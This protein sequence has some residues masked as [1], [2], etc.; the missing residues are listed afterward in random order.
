[1]AGSLPDQAVV[2]VQ[3]PDAQ[4]PANNGRPSYSPTFIFLY[5][6]IFALYFYISYNQVYSPTGFSSDLPSH[7]LFANQF[8]HGQY[9]ASYP[10]LYIIWFVVSHLLQ[11]TTAQG[12][13]IVDSLLA[14][15]IAII[16]RKVL[17]Y[18]QCS[19]IE[20][21]VYTAMLMI[22]TPIYVPFFN[23]SLYL[24]QIN[25]TVYHNPTILAV[26]PFA[27]LS[28]LCYAKWF[29]TKSANRYFALAVLAILISIVMKPNFFLVFA[30]AAAIYLLLHG[31]RFEQWWKTG[32]IFVL[33]VVVLAVQYVITYDQPD[34]TSHIGL[35]HPFR[36][37]AI[38]S[39]NPLISILISVS[40][41]L[42]ILVFRW[43][44]AVHN[45]YLM[46]SWLAL[47][48]GIVEYAMLAEKGQRFV[49]GNL[50]WGMDS[51]IPLV[52]LFSVVEWARWIRSE[53]D[54]GAR[55]HL[56]LTGTALALHV[57]SGVFLLLMVAGGLN[58]WG[59]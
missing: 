11:L 2:D 4:A 42:L 40:F 48:G 31:R 51:V 29:R 57:V 9:P 27:Y 56:H 13:I 3:A 58:Y 44:H 5:A 45:D 12:A 39:P 17:E 22:V 47:C 1:M 52:F 18:S 33:A 46:L 34:T 32:V 54:Q 28:V 26:K 36:L 35:T 16:I 50:G 37:W 43:R 25:P 53:R 23:R 20:Q 24:G 14:V 8:F 21:L 41:P 55:W 15:A 38:Q 10:G 49:H 59:P 19:E 30:P 7:I 6:G